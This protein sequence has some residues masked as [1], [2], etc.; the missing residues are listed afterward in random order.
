MRFHGAWRSRRGGDLGVEVVDLLR[1]HARDL[2][3]A[4]RRDRA[5][6]VLGLAPAIRT[7]VGGK[8][9]E[10]RSTRMP[11]AL[12]TAKWPELVQHDQRADAQEVR[13]QVT[14]PVWQGRAGSRRPAACRAGV[15]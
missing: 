7:I 6:R 12:A 4:A 15:S 9:S 13:T 5:D 14:G 11:T 1:A 8:N 3:V 10:K 2:H